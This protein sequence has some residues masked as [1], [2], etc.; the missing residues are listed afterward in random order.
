MSRLGQLAKE[1]NVGIA[2]A[3]ELL[4]KKGYEG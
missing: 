2:T 1:L 3:T 4:K